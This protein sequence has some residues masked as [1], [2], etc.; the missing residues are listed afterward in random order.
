MT[1]REVAR[2]LGVS[3]EWLRRLEREGRVPRATRDL[4][5]YRRYS[6]EDILALR[7]VLYGAPQLSE[8]ERHPAQ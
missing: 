3:G 1:V 7:R 2:R 4:N 5:G 6:E 8:E